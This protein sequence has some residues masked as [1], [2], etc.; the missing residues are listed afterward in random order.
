MLAGTP[1][2]SVSKALNGWRRTSRT[3]SWLLSTLSTLSRTTALVSIF[4]SLIILISNRDYIWITCTRWRSPRPGQVQEASGGALRQH[5]HDGH[6]EILHPNRGNTL[7][8]RKKQW[9]LHST[10]CILH[11]SWISYIN[12]FSHSSLHFSNSSFTIADLYERA[13]VWSH[14]ASPI[15]NSNR[16]SLIFGKCCQKNKHL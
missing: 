11:I 12:I 9:L 13:S 6:G 8:K 2:T 10:L 7:A 16:K 15:L 14:Q 1:A 5:A 3:R 4:F